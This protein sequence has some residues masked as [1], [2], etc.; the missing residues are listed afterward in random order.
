MAMVDAKEVEGIIVARLNRFGRSVLD[1]ARNVERLRGAGGR[2][3]SATEQIDTETSMGRF[4]LVI[5]S[6]FA[7]LEADR[8]GENWATAREFAAE[9]GAYL[10]EAPVGYAKTPEG[11]LVIDEAVAPAIANAFRR[12]AAGESWSKIAA[13]LD[14]QGVAAKRG[15]KWTVATVRRAIANRAYVGESNG[16][17]THEPVVSRS[18][19]EAANIVKGIVPA[20]SGRASGL[21]S[22]ILRCAGCRYAMK[23]SMSRSRHGKPFTEYRCKSS[24]GES[25]GGRCEAAASVKSNVIED[26]VMA[27]FWIWYGEQCAIGVDPDQLTEEAEAKVLRARAE[28]DAVLDR[29]LAEILGGDRAPAYLDL[30]RRRQQ[31]VDVAEAELGHVARRAHAAAL[32]E[33][34]LREIWSDLS[35]EDQRKYLAS[36][37]EC[38]F[39]RRGGQVPIGERA[40]LCL[41]GEAPELP[42]R[43]RRWSPRP[44]D[45]PATAEALAE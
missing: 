24:R 27:A 2:L 15:G 38:V 7:E 29:E 30:V 31:A 26:F 37:F 3:V 11:H 10:A 43:G 5:L 32:G 21:L 40:L 8:I 17:L 16:E 45:F 28:R 14:S 44:F 25:A 23:L 1:I 22:G 20:R 41:D 13:W 19:F 39:V 4:F 42:T 34:D 35:L 36:V 33:V 6:G 12:R 18:V 9:R